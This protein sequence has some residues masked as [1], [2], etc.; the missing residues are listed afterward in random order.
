MK[1][2]T[3]KAMSIEA[4]TSK[5][6]SLSMLNSYKLSSFV[7]KLIVMSPVLITLFFGLAWFIPETYKLASWASKENGLAETLTFLFLL[8]GSMF[9][10]SLAWK[11]KHN[12]EHNLLVLFIITFSLAL[13]IVAME[14]ISWGQQFFKFQTPESLKTIN[15]QNEVNLHNIKGLQ[16]QSEFIHLFFGL[17]GLISIYFNLYI[18]DRVKVP[19]VLLICFITITVISIADLLVDYTFEKHELTYF[20]RRLSEVNEMFIGLAGFSYIILLTQKFM[21]EWNEN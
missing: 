8:F 5:S 9:G 21:A 12:K 2:L 17:A 1:T 16:G 20:M 10:G 14:E 18:L 3:K 15:E 4:Q 6:T 13:F 11:M 7:V 19:K